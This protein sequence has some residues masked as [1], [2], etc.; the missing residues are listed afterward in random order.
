MKHLD[1]SHIHDK[2]AD[3]SAMDSFRSARKISSSLVR[4]KLYLSKRIGDSF[5]CTKNKFQV[6]LNVNDAD[7]FGSTG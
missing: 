5:K 2:K 4:P 7:A 1:I 6:C 3:L